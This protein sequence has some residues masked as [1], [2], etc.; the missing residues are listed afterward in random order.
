MVY[1]TKSLAENLHV[2]AKMIEDA[3]KFLDYKIE[4]IES[5][6]KEVSNNSK[7]VNLLM[8]KK[9]CI[10]KGVR[11]EEEE[12]WSKT[13]EIVAITMNEICQVDLDGE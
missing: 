6:L 1:D 4:D 9:T 10:L 5:K 13:K 3:T 2:K 7:E 8:K 12:T 11:K